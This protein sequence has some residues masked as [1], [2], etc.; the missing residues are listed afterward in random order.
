MDFFFLSEEES[1]NFHLSLQRYFDSL[2]LKSCAPPWALHTLHPSQAAIA[3]ETMACP[4]GWTH[5]VRH[6]ELCLPPPNPALNKVAGSIIS[7]MAVCL[8]ILL[9]DFPLTFAQAAQ[10][11][12][13]PSPCSANTGQMERDPLSQLLAHT[14]VIRSGPSSFLLATSP[15]Q[16]FQPPL[17]P[18][19]TLPPSGA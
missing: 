19:R 8:H 5:W 13:N 16:S 6:W 4:P 17:L 3:L 10:V 18:E 12:P 14:F 9:I 11:S 2:K 1:Q 15:N 7:K